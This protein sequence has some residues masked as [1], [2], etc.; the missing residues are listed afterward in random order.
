MCVF[1]FAVFYYFYLLLLVSFSSIFDIDPSVTHLVIVCF[2]LCIYNCIVTYLVF[3]TFFVAYMFST[4][5][6]TGYE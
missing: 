3:S 4:M 5:S 6:I 2:L 1:N